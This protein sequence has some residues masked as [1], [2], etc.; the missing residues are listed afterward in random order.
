MAGF[1]KCG[2]CPS[3]ADCEEAGMCL[4]TLVTH[5]YVM[6]RGGTMSATVPA[7]EGDPFGGSTGAA[8][9]TAVATP[10]PTPAKPATA[11][12]APSAPG[13]GSV[14]ERIFAA[15]DAALAKLDAQRGDKEDRAPS[16]HQQVLK[17]ARNMA[18]PQLVEAGVNINSA[19]KGSSMWLQARQ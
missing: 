18:I 14:T 3:Q 16:I 19:R 5:T 13:A 15:C 11:R 10:Q 1:V 4:N 2:A 7:R 12:A 8:S 17:D 9:A 6:K